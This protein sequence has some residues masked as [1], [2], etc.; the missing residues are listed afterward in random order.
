MSHTTVPITVTWSR[1]ECLDR[2]EDREEADQGEITPDFSPEHFSSTIARGKFVAWL[3]GETYCFEDYDLPEVWP[4]PDIAAETVTLHSTDAGDCRV[5]V[6]ATFE[7][8]IPWKA[9][10]SD[11][12]ACN[13]IFFSVSDGIELHFWTGEGDPGPGPGVGLYWFN[14]E[15]HFVQVGSVVIWDKRG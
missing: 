9:D 10:L 14:D 11:E 13:D 6:T 1:A 3:K 12:S 5:S 2:P 4:A 15:W 7:L 8:A